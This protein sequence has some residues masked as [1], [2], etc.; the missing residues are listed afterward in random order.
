MN[1]AILGIIVGI[2]VPALATVACGLLAKFAPREKCA[3][4]L[5]APVLRIMII[6]DT[7]LN[8]K[9]GK[10]TSEKIAES[11]WGTFGYVLASTGTRIMNWLRLRDTDKTVK[12]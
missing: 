8:I 5:W 3:D 7:F 9:V 12:G 11:V 1:D 2:G 4:W 6:V 10:A